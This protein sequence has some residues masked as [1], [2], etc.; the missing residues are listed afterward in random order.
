MKPHLLRDS[1]W[2]AHMPDMNHAHAWIYARSASEAM[3]MLRRHLT[4]EFIV[5][6]IA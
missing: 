5:S 3:R 6:W 2:Q 4:P 1:R